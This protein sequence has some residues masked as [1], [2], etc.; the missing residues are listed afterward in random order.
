MPYS[1]TTKDG[2][3][4]DNIPDDVPQDAPE[5][6]ARVQEIR[7]QQTGQQ[8]APEQQAA[9]E[10]PG[11]VDRFTR[12]AELAG[13]A[14]AEGAY[15]TV[16]IVS[17]PIAAVLNQILPE[18]HKI[19]PAR[20]SMSYAL[21]QQGV[22]VP[23]TAGERIGQQAMQSMVGG[24]GFIGTG[25]TLAGAASPVVS[26]V[27]EML[28]AQPGQQLAGSAGAGAA[29]QTAQ[30]AGLGPVAQLAAGLAGGLAGGKAA[31]K[32][33][34][35]PMQIQPTTTR[36]R[37]IPVE[38]MTAEELATAAKKAVE[39]GISKTRSAMILAEQAMP[40]QSVVDAA[41]RLGI[42]D[43]LQ[44][45]HVSSNQ[46]YR[47]LA[48][49]VKS[50]PG[51]QARA[52]EVQ[53]LVKVGE[54]ASKLIEEIGGTGD[55]SMLDV[56]VKSRIGSAISELDNQADRLF[57]SLREKIPQRASASPINT[58]TH[59]R[60]RAGDLGGV[61]NLSNIEKDIIKK[62][63]PVRVGDGNIRNPTYA[64][65]DDVRRDV[66]L[67][68]S[69]NRGPFKDSDTGILKD[70]Y[71]VI[72]EDQSIV[73]NNF[74]A[75][76]IF[77]AAKSAVR[78]RKGFEDDLISLY[79][80]NLDS[81]IVTGIDGAIKSLSKGDTSKLIKLLG[82]IP[83]DMRQQVV[84]D[85]IS[86]AFGKA[87]TN[88]QLNFNTFSKWY[89]GVLANK[90]AH[91]ALMANL[92]AGARRSIDDLY[93]VSKSIS[94]ATRERITTGRIQA[95]QDEL[96]GADS[97]IGSVYSR[98]KSAAIGV[99]VEIVASSIGAPGAGLASGITA[100]LMRNKPSTIKAADALISSPEFQR[101]AVESS[102]KKIVSDGMLRRVINSKSFKDF[103]NAV[104]IPNDFES[105][106][107]WLLSSIYASTKTTQENE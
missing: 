76:E 15:G 9:Q 4:I 8:V 23:E 5:L 57:L 60:N 16:G 6:K 52:Q 80:K 67:A 95:V 28:A 21:T 72:S 79:G 43:Y 83:E 75:G 40:D 31:G 10:Q 85:G 38:P 101:L 91:N 89:D 47:E 103:A 20:E 82:T 78:A 13:R 94:E 51:S 50:I 64:L 68:I 53:G 107:K 30:E 27:G 88:G 81:S 61:K 58:L 35:E 93:K 54:R 26:G 18:G 90:Q 63:S 71:R 24:A 98:A 65:L 19:A 70:I 45:D 1:I 66:G 49:A 56:S 33:V 97:L 32:I 44:P 102:T 106:R 69:K 29:A 59:I 7:A 104:D 87:T 12:Q 77:E 14:I 62:L 42:D 22:P 99:P 39:P 73:A 84:A 74:G 96:R 100:S 55:M 3:T 11:I 48:Q 37:E 105:K 46:S 17:D 36:P 34:K 41:K 25:R 92:P 2:I 86:T